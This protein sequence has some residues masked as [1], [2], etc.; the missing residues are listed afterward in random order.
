MAT[1]R[2]IGG[3]EGEQSIA[4]GE[5]VVQIGRARDNDI[6]LTGAEKGVSRLHAELRFEN[7]RYVI[8]DLQ[9]Q[10]GTWV[11]GRRVERAEVPPGAEIALGEYRLRIQGELPGAGGSAPPPAPMRSDPVGE[12]TLRPPVAP[13]P[14]VP[15]AGASAPAAPARSLMTAAVVGVVLLGGTAAV[16]M[17]RPPAPASEAA[18]VPEPSA[19]PAA[20]GPL[21]AAAD[22]GA[23]QDRPVPTPEPPVDPVGPGRRQSAVPAAASG[24]GR[25]AR[26]PGESVEAW[27]SRSA[28]LQTRYGYSKAAMERGDFAA[29]SG[30]FEAILL[31]EPGF[32]DAAQLLVQAQAGLRSNARS[33]HQAGTRLEASGDWV[34]ALQKY[35]QARQIFSGIPGLADDV[36]RMKEKLRIAGTNAFKQARAHDEA[37]RAEE[38]LREYEKA[39]QWLPAEDPNRQ[40]AR[41][42]IEQLKKH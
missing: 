37:G 26:K 3:E 24:G 16:W 23:G 9:S 6:V 25:V 19:P 17:L 14:R 10:N 27:R 33:L 18:P 39:V 15:A 8:V 20:A 2:I 5:G 22:N 4:L 31:E 35:E 13:P 29:A 1:L 12:L 42:R 30:G 38:A 32:L 11:N 21:P 34:G 36:Q 40:I 7:G 41:T 28:A